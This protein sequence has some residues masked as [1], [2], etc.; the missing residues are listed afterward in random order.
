MSVLVSTDSLSEGWIRTLALVRDARRGR[1][2]HVITAV[3]QPGLEIAGARE[4]L[5]K[6]LAD[7]GSQSVDTVAGTIF[8]SALYPDPGLAW[9]PDLPRKQSDELDS[10]AEELYDNYIDMLPILLTADGNK[11]GTYFSRMIT[12]PGKEAGGTNQLRL[13][14]MRLRSEARA[15]R[16]TNNTLDIDVAA[17]ALDTTLSGLQVYAATDKRTRGFPCLAHIDLTLLDST[18]HCTAV[19]RHQYLIEKAY[20][21]LVGL[22]ALLHFLCQQGGCTPGELVVHATLADAQPAGFS[23]SIDALIK[24]SLDVVDANG[25]D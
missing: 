18:L 19:Y 8:P 24:D 5:D 25:G 16:R 14:V 22:S 10:A 6:V 21:N 12:W 1:L 17:D 4:V 3:R 15:G 9:S 11:R 2:P 23:H 13:R 20:G 7:S